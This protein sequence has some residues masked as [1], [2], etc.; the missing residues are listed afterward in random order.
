MIATIAKVPPSMGASTSA[1]FNLLGLG[2][3]LR[4]KTRLRVVGTYLSALVVLVLVA[5]VGVVSLTDA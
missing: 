3:K 5:G 2:I 1:T 4:D